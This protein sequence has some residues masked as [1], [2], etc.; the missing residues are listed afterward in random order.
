MD[1]E[2]YVGL[3][4]LLG[5]LLG[6]LVEFAIERFKIKSEKKIHVSKARFDKEFEI[7]Q[8]LS[9]KGLSMVYSIGEI[10]LSV[11]GFGNTPEKL[12]ENKK[13]TCDF[14]NEMEFCCKKY[15]PFIS[16]G[17]YEKYKRLI[18]LTTHI[19]K[20]YVYWTGDDDSLNIKIHGVQY[21]GKSEMR[22]GI[23][24]MQKELSV[25]S[26]DILDFVREYLNGLEVKE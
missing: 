19:F 20:V 10:V 13:N 22:D 24:S 9:A 26:D 23:T 1:S 14:L 17:V 7:Y 5:T 18:E 12:E 6:F 3:F 4:T 15:A 8:E 2:V 16:K 25:L 21:N 11:N